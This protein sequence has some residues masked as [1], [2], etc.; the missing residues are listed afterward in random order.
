MP[1]SS[2]NVQTQ[3]RWR[4]AVKKFDATKKIPAD[5]WTTLEEAL[6]LAPSSYG[7]QPWRFTVVTNAAKRAELQ[8][9]S[10]G[11]SQI[12]EASHLVVFSARK[13]MT[14][15]D[16]D[17]LIQR[18][19]EV[20]GASATDLEG[21]KKMMLGSISRM[22]PEEQA[23]WNARQV[24]IALGG[25]LSAAADLG[26]DACPMEGISGPDYDNMLGLEAQGYF[27]CCVATL[28]YRSAEDAYASAPKVRFKKEEVIQYV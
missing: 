20:R 24:Y 8:K 15:V 26:V 27:T 12:V 1:I 11:Q 19:I 13:T 21:Y 7:L 2:D 23:A 17:R 14:L 28:G 25:F 4:Y 22:K 9:V 16:V 5:L 6:H 18:I 10:F 3:L